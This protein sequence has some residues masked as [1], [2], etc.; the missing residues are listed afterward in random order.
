MYFS[1]TVELLDKKE[2]YLPGEDEGE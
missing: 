1:D 2:M